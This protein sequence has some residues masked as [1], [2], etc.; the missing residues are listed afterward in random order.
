M[1]EVRWDGGVRSLTAGQERETCPLVVLLPGLGAMGYLVDTLAACG[2]WTSSFLLDVPG[3][4]RRPPRP[5]PPEVPAIAATVAGWLDLVAG[6]RPVVLVGHSTAAQAALHVAVDRPGR[7]RALVL[8]GPTFPPEQRRFPPLARACLRDLPR[9]N[10]GLVPA[11][12]PYYL[13][14]GVDLARMVRSAQRDRPEDVIPAVRCPTLLVRGVHDTFAHQEWL[15][16]L[17]AAARDGWSVTAPGAH[18]FPFRRGELT[19]ELIA[20][21]AHRAGLTV[22]PDRSW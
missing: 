6:D 7:V 14:G 17:T 4:G 2:R 12:L 8:M 21:A 16:R 10:I 15:D 18:T 13:R 5:C 20:R 9:E 22:H 3:F 1:T 19:G 11:V